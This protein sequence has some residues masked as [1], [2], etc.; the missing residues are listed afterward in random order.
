MTIPLLN[1]LS[2][3]L[4]LPVSKHEYMLVYFLDAQ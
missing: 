3:H 1:V 2:A 4:V